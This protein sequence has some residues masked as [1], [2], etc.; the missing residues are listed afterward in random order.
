MKAFLVLISIVVILTG[1][2]IGLSASTPGMDATGQFVFGGNLGLMMIIIIVAV[3]TIASVAAKFIT[4][5]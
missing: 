3:I 5:F 4:E 2:V 1:I